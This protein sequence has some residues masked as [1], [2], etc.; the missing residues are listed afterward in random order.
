M[1]IVH[2]TVIDLETPNK[3]LARIVSDIVGAG[4]YQEDRVIRVDRFLTQEQVDSILLEANETLRLKEEEGALKAV[5]ESEAARVAQLLEASRRQKEASAELMAI[6]ALLAS[7]S[8]SDKNDI[9][10]LNSRK[11]FLSKLQ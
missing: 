11:D 2:D 9:A 8:V 7:G 10:I 3:K 5:E 6:E 4:A 1:K